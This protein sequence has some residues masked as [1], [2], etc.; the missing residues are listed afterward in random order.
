MN[1]CLLAYSSVRTWCNELVYMS[2]DQMSSVLF[3]VLSLCCC[4]CVYLCFVT[5][6]CT[7]IFDQWGWG[8]NPC[9]DPYL[10]LH[11]DK[12]RQ[13]PF[14]I[15][16]SAILGLWT[17]RAVKLLCATP[18]WLTQ[19]WAAE[20][21]CPPSCCNRVSTTPGNSGNLL[22]G[23]PGNFCVTHVDDRLHFFPIMIKLGTGS[24]I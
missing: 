7:P 1:E 21:V 16:T 2:A 3:N 20:W 11:T 12:A 17:D 4:A 9:L 24:L 14:E 13:G 10:N 19:A 6:A 8:V 22:Y 23:P 15:C 5:S 18:P